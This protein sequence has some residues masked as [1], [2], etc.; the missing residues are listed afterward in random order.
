MQVSLGT[1]LALT[2]LP[3][4]LWIWFFYR[5]DK[6][7]KE[8][9]QLV[10]KT[11]LLGAVM[12]IP[13][14]IA[15]SPFR[16]ALSGRAGLLALFIVAI[17][18]VGLIEEV[19]KYFAIKTSAYNNIEFDEQMDGII[20]GISAGLGFA[21]LENLMYLSAFGTAVGLIRAIL[22]NLAHA[23]FSGVV[24]YHLGLAKF[25]KEQETAYIFK[26]LSIAIFLH[27]FYDFLV[28]GR[29]VP[30]TV[31]VAVIFISY[32]YLKGKIRLAQEH[33]PFVGNDGE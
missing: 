20:Y 12:V 8:P 3:G 29:I 14:G 6:Y 1:L 21:A 15:E 5:Q 30:P 18:V 16:Y 27:G 22:T 33:S 28:I 31:V 9:K 24:G 10:V 19:L 32:W 23:S 13:A 4:I 2:V 11:F 25:H 17:F 7:E 26:G